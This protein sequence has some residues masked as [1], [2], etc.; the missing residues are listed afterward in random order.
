MTQSYDLL[1]TNGLCV[2]PSGTVEAD[3]GVRN[4]KIVKIGV[5]SGASAETVFDARGL[6]VLPGVIDTQVH[7]REP[8]MEHKEDLES[9]TRAAVKGGVT[10]VFEMPNTSPLTDSAAALAEKFDRAAGR[11]WTDHAFFVGATGENASRLRELEL[12]PGCCG[13]KIF[14]GSSTGNLLVEDDATLEKVLTASRRRCSVHA[15]DEYRLRDRFE[16]AEKGGHPRAHPDWRDP[17]SA[18]TATQ[19]IV[20]LA[21]KTGHPVHVLHISTAEEIVFLGENKDIATVEATPQHLTLE[22][23]DCYDRLGALAQMNPPIRDSQH[24]AGLWHGVQTG[25]VDVIGSDHAPHSLEEKSSPYPRSPSGMPGVQTLVPIMLNHVNAGRLS[26]ERFVDL[27]AAG[28]QRLFG[29][30]GKGRIAV[31]YD[32]DFTIVDMA[33]KRTIENSWIESKC[34]WTPYDGMQIT[35]W[36]VATLLRG[37][38]AMREDTLSDA[39]T[40]RPVRFNDSLVPAAD[41]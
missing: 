1:I 3:I 37:Q 8:G 29:I 22:A 9:G 27:T 32:A 17:V 24:R 38:F 14:M 20:R 31:G 28:A 35:G 15:E 41:G 13:V 11:A 40:G 23:P 25:I 34:G 21:R 12:F 4:G 10:T 18:L 19:R 16:I 39:P 33:A 7:F 26:L 2:T 5:P 30:A 36:P 6:H